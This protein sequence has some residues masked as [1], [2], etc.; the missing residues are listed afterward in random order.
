MARPVTNPSGYGSFPRNPS[1]GA[2][3]QHS[4]GGLISCGNCFVAVPQDRFYAVESFGSFQRL[5]EPGFAF[6]GCDI[7]GIC[8][9]F[10]SISRRVEQ[11]ECFVETKTKDNVFVLVRVAIQQEVIPEKAKDAMYRLANVDSQIDSYVSDIVRSR[12]PAMSLDESF[13]KKDAIGDAIMQ[14]LSRQMGAYGFAVRN[15]LVTEIKPQQ[16]VMNAMNEIN[17]QRRL[18]DAAAMK[19]EADKILIVKAAEAQRDASRLQ[20]EGIAEQR[21]AIVEGLRSSI[22]GGTG[23]MLTTPKISELLLISQYFETLKEIGANSKSNAIFM[24]HSP[25]DG[26]SDIAAQIRNGVMTAR[27]GAPEQ[28]RMG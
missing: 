3:K 24:P 11:N 6:V 17:K 7:A 5:L 22:A 20:G 23:E 16:D 25:T 28:A 18:R 15:A 21:S 8:I 14:E 9:Q 2:G 26:L 1:S 4:V 10:R 13:E 19:A 27:A 12:V